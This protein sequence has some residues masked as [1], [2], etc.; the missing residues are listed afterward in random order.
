MVGLDLQELELLGEIEGAECERDRT[1]Q[2]REKDIG[3][4]ANQS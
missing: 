3:G 4:G 1:Q 2:Q